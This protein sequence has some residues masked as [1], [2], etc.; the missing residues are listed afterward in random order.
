MNTKQNAQRRLAHCVAV[1]CLSIAFTTSAQAVPISD[2]LFQVTIGLETADIDRDGLTDNAAGFNNGA[3]FAYLVNL[4][5]F[6]NSILEL[7]VDRSGTVL[8]MNAHLEGNLV[9]PDGTLITDR[10]LIDLSF[11]PAMHIDG[12]RLIVK[13]SNANQ[14]SPQTAGSWHNPDGSIGLIDVGLTGKT[15]QNME[16]FSGTFS[17][18]PFDSNNLLQANLLL[19]AEFFGTAWGIFA[20][21]GTF[22][23]Y[24]QGQV[25]DVRSSS[26]PVPEPGTLCLLSVTSALALLKRRSS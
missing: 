26:Q 25:I 12:E 5:Q 13:D 3:G 14:A 8:E 17:R 19:G 18:N 1:F 24:L 6:N 15:N 9:Y 16:V 10:S 11:G 23:T 2:Q 7:L 22:D 4:E 21:N 20:Q